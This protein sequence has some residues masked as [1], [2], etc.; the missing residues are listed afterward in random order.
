MKGNKFMNKQD[1]TRRDFLQAACIGVGAL[2]V[3]TS[4]ANVLNSSKSDQ[5]KSGL[6]SCDV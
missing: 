2:S 4:S 6:P 5:N 1:F 3:S